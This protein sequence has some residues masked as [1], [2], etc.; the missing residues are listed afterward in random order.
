MSNIYKEYIELGV[1]FKNHESNMKPINKLVVTLF[2]KNI[3]APLSY[4]RQFDVAL[5]LM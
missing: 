1:L 3:I 2:F 5:T 4:T